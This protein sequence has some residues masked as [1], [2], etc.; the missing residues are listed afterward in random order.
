MGLAIGYGVRSRSRSSAASLRSCGAA[1]SGGARV[2]SRM[3]IAHVFV[4]PV[5][6]ATLIALHLFL[7]VPHHTQFRGGR[8][9]EKR[10]VGVPAFPGQAP[11]SLG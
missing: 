2:W 7:V 10:L 4:L 9:T 1:V 3:Y 11:R 6:I 8:R 5:L